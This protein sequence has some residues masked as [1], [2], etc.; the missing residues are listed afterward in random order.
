LANWL[1]RRCKEASEGSLSPA[2]PALDQIPGWR[3]AQRSG[4]PTRPAGSS[5]WTRRPPT[6]PPTTNGPGTIRPRTSRNA[7]WA[8]GCIPKRITRRAGKL[9]AAKEKQL[10]E[11]VPGWRQGRERSAQRQIRDRE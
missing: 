5:A 7:P 4:T 10:D 6:W 3:E 1:P 8:S 9:D 2:Y 11:V